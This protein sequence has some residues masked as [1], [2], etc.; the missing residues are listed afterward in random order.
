MAVIVEVEQEEALKYKGN[1]V[2]AEVKG[3]AQRVLFIVKLVASEIKSLPETPDKNI[4]MYRLEGSLPKEEDLKGKSQSISK[5]YKRW[6]SLTETDVKTICE[7]MVEGVT[8]VIEVPEDYTD[9][10]FV[11]R[12]CK[13]YEN[14]RFTGGL[15]FNSKSV[16]LGLVG[17]QDIKKVGVTKKYKA[18]T[19]RGTENILETLDRKEVKLS[20]ERRRDI[21]EDVVALTIQNGIER[22]EI[23]SE[24]RSKDETKPQEELNMSGLGEVKLPEVYKTHK[25]RSRIKRV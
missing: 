20:T 22:R 8:P 12:M 17:E 9:Y 25:R 1:K 11:R 15:L 21:E 2:Y 6:N 13:K 4:V 10:V 24:G 18:K 14:I 3:K 16:R 5:I 19:Y 7:G 23:I